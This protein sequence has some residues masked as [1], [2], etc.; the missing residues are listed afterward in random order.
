MLTSADVRI[1]L[2]SMDTA[3]RGFVCDV[4]FGQSRELR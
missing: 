1:P 2:S 3:A 4:N